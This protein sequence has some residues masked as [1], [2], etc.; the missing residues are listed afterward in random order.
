MQ[1]H[2]LGVGLDAKTPSRVSFLPYNSPMLSS[3]KLTFG[4]GST[5][6]DTGAGAD[7][8]WQHNNFKKKVGYKYN[9]NTNIN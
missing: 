9:R 1:K 7:M 6:K 2:P 8:V 3:A 4:I 5:C